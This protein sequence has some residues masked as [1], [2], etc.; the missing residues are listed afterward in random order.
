MMIRVLCRDR[1][2]GF[3]E[4]S[5]LDDFVRRGI[6]I[7][8]FRPGSNE[9]VDVRNNAIRKKSNVQYTGA[10]RRSGADK[11]MPCVVDN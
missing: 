2:R 1:S 10:E 5:N 6:V 9:W 7:A 4:A 3:V 8:F 11:N